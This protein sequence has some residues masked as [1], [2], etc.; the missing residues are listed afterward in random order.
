M[1]A[2]SGSSVNSNRAGTAPA[3]Q[4]ELYAGLRFRGHRGG[5]IKM[6]RALSRLSLSPLD[7]VVAASLVVLFLCVWAI[8]LPWVCRFW[9]LALRVGAKEIALPGALATHSYHLGAYLAFTISNPTVRVVNPTPAVWW[10]TAAIVAA[11]FAAT[12]FFPPRLI[13]ITL[14]LRTIL[15]VQASAL[16]YFALIP[17]RFPRTPDGYLEGL[18]MYG[19]AL[20]SFVP[21]LYGLTYYIFD[22]G[23]TRKI[24]V[25]LLTMLHLSV[26][27]PLQTLLHAVILEKSVLFMPILY[28]VFGLPVEVLIIVGF[29]SWAM[30]W[31]PREPAR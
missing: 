16:A 10:W 15:A 17:A 14:L 7:L 4:P 1:A 24:L 28:I 29:Y 6:H 21:V 2:A 3:S 25:T 27:L 8:S 18:V 13:P 20:I 26:F 23:L 19:L 22:F 11:L 5:V 30:S 12:L 31:A 9:T